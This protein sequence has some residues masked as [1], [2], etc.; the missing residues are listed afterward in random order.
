M[1]VGGGLAPGGGGGGGER[2]SRDNNGAIWLVSSEV[3]VV[4]VMELILS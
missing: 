3:S 4:D 2:K 1:G